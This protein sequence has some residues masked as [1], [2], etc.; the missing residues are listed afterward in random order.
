MIVAEADG[1]Y[2][3]VT[4]PD[5]AALAGHLAHAWGNA[6]FDRPEPLAPLAL[7]AH[8]HDDGWWRY[9]RRPHLHADGTPVNFTELPAETWVECYESGVDAAVELD[10]Y[11]GLLVSMHGAG[12]RRRRYGLSP[13]WTDTPADYAAF[14]ERQEAL[15]SRLA[16]DLGEAGRLS[17]ADRELLSTLHERGEP[18]ATTDSQLWDGYRLLQAWDVLS[19][20]LCTTVEPPGYASVAEVPT[21]DGSAETL[22][23]EAGAVGVRVSPYPF[24]DE[25]LRVAVPARTVPRAALESEPLEAFYA[26]PRTHLRF[27]FER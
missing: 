8:R 3:F 9:D 21:G 20:A 18:P 15:Q 17:A 4:Q 25:P 16:A 7:A 27:A 11:A 19:L 12:L 14:V 5:H 1:A 10:D 2:Q 6:R 23:L 22:S 26:A 24:D 13:D